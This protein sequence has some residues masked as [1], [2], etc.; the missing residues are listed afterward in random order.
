MT[1]CPTNRLLLVCATALV[2]LLAAAGYWVPGWG[3]LVGVLAAAA[4][5]ALVDAVVVRRSARHLAVRL[6]GPGHV[7]QGHAFELV[8]TVEGG[9]RVRLALDAPDD[10]VGADEVVEGDPGPGA[11]TVSWRI[12]PRERGRLSLDT[13]FH[14]TLSPLGLWAAR[15]RS[16]AGSQVHVYPDLK[17]ER[18]A[19]APLFLRRAAFGIHRTREIGKGREFEQL[20]DYTHGDSYEDIDWKATA[21]RQRPVT[22]VHQVERSQDVYVV[23]DASRRSQRRLTEVESGGATPPTQIDRFVRSALALVLS[24]LQQGDRPGLVTFGATLRSF[25]RAAGGRPQYNACRDA[26][27]DL[28]AVPHPPDFADVFAELRNRVRNRALLIFLT[29]LDDPV[30]AS[31]FVEEVSPLARQHVVLVGQLQAP[32]VAPVFSRRDEP[33]NDDDVYRHLAGQMLWDGARQTKARLRARGVHCVSAR[34]EGLVG[35]MV[36]AYLDI[37]RRQLL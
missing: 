22:K 8:A 9:G 27:F 26:L 2:P 36:S 23:V 15:G 28:Q 20:R 4:V 29:D 17:Q 37:K 25:L 6:E 1:L 19:L 24:A 10:L 34:S 7:T 12:T 31:Q 11:R 14:E 30:L 18:G 16:A 32:A 13:V 33:K 35:E 5:P 3:G 21:R